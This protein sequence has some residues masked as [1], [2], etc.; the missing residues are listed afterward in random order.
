MAHKPSEHDHHREHPSARA[1]EDPPSFSKSLSGEETARR[2]RFSAAEQR[3]FVAEYARSSLPVNAFCEM[4]GISRGSLARWRR[5]HG[6]QDRHHNSKYARRFTPEERRA[7]VEAFQRSGRTRAE[8]ASLWGISPASL[9]KWSRKY[10]ESGPRGLEPAPRKARAPH[11]FARTIPEDV[12]KEVVRTK[13]QHPSW[14]MRRI[15]DFLL[16][17]NSHKLSAGSVRNVLLESGI[18]PSPAPQ[19]RRKPRSKLPRRFER[20]RPRELWQSD[21]TSYVLARP[22]RRVYLTVFLDDHS[23]YVVS[24]RLDTHQRADLVIDCLM[25]GI[26]RF[27]KPREVLTD[28]GRQYFAWR[29]KCRFQKLLRREGIQH[30]VS[31]TPHPQTLGKCERLWK[32]VFDEF[33]ERA[34]PDTLEEARE[35]LAHYFAHFNH[36]RTHQGIDGLVP[37][38]RFFDAEDV[39]RKAI[40]ERLTDRELQLAIDPRERNPVYLTGQIGAESLSMHG[41]QGRLV[42]QTSDGRRRELELEDL[43]APQP[44]QP[45]EKTD[46]PR[47]HDSP[48]TH[49]RTPQT[50]AIQYASDDGSFGEG[51]VES[52][53]ARGPEEGARAVHGDARI[54]DGQEDEERGRSGPRPA[55]GAHLAAEPAGAFGDARGAPEATAPADERRPADGRRSALGA[56]EAHPRP[57][58]E[59]LAHRGPR[60]CA[61]NGPMGAGSDGEHGGQAQRRSP[62]TS[63]T[64]SSSATPSKSE[65]GSEGNSSRIHRA[66]RRAR[67]WLKPSE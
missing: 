23:R 38:D 47:T 48:Q 39:V 61:E 4:H 55:A 37:A 15:R 20:A 63:E 11:T 36:F 44:T 53:N 29:G 24:W 14:G 58:S 7:A 54:L 60:P 64:E 49:A 31:R 40:E 34:R 46:D 25:E 6:T 45:Q 41:E 35:R 10:R 50:D 9:D 56:E 13:T 65:S 3:H 5:L 33:W 8:F 18:E 21:I 17:F 32:T 43:G 30:V 2:R 42:I 66:L 59:T 28:Q 1:P 22:G 52:S 16:R 57:R 51:A 26:A 67:S 19:K 62:C 27:G 12:R